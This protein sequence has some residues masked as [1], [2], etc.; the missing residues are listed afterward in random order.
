[1]LNG[2]CTAQVLWIDEVF[3]TEVALLSILA[4]LPTGTAYLLS[5]DIHQFGPCFDSWRGST[6]PDGAFARSSLYYVL[7]GG[8][9]LTLT[10]CRRS[11]TELFAFY[12]SMIS[13]GSRF[14]LD[15]HQ[16]LREARRLYHFT[17]PSRH[18]VCISHRNRRKINR[19]VTQAFMPAGARFLRA[20]A[21]TEE[22][23]WVWPGCPLLGASSCQRA[24]VQNNVY[25]V[26][27]EVSDTHVILEGG[28]RLTF[29][30]VLSQTR[31][32]WCRTIASIQGWE[33]PENEELRVWDTRNPHFGMRH[34][35]VCISRSKDSSR[36]HVT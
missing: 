28:R 35:Y 21:S 9:R 24:H 8:C 32:A 2:A 13:G 12:S 4:R 29:A 15:L 5:G 1:M 18:N 27:Q 10:E 30:Q 16:V 14:E 7:A 6:V 34:L 3:Q 25:Y 33:V 23:L 26:I 31:P 11:D 20:N 22:S 19:E 36:I 17:G